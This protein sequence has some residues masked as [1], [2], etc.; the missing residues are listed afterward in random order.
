MRWPE[1]P[2]H[3]ALNP[4]YFFFVLFWFG[5]FSFLVFL[6]GFKGQVRWPEGQSH[7]A[8]NPPYL[9]YLFLFF[10]FPFFGS[11]RQK[12]LFPPRRGHCL[13]IFECL[14]FFLLSLF[15]PPHFSIPLSLSLSF[16]SF[17]FPSCLSF[18][19][20][21]LFLVFLSFFPILSSL[22]L[23]HERNNIKTL[24]CN[25]FHQSFLFWVFCL[26]FLPIPFSYLCFLLISSYVFCST[27]M[28]LVEIINVE[29]KTPILVKRGVATKRCFFNEPVFCKM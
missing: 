14:P 15:W 2:P 4:P 3:L 20:F 16:F 12:S 6:G 29:K 17:F 22:L 8:L 11:N 25:F 26:V 24:N 28:F 27:S 9:I 13:F 7:L 5:F 1:W 23:F 18:F 19:A 21:F 10:F